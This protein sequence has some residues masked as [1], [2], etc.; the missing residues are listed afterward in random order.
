[1]V[2]HFTAGS[3]AALSATMDSVDQGANGIPVNSVALKGSQLSL[4]VDAVHGAYEGTLSPDA[5]AIKGTWSQGMSLE[6]NLERG[7]LKQAEAKPAPPPTSTP[8]GKARSTPGS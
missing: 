1:V 2:F 5:T 7:A 3:N 8:A 4:A 6:L